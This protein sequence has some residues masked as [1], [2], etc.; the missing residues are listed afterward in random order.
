MR[1]PQQTTLGIIGAGQLG[2]MLA[3][4]GIP[5]GVK[6]VFLAS[7]NN[8]PA[9]ELGQV[10][11]PLEPGALESFL[12]AADMITYESENTDSQLIRQIQQT[13][14][15]YPGEAALYT[16]Q[17][18]FREK[19]CF[20][21]LGIPTADFALV[22]SIHSLQEAVTKIGLPAI[23]KT[24]TEGYDGKGQF[25]IENPEQINQAWL[26]IG[27]REAILEAKINFKRELS[28]VAVRSSKGELAYYP[29]VENHHRQGILRTTYAPAPNLDHSLT[30]MADAY[31]QKLLQ[32]L[33]YVG[34]M[35]LEL[36]EDEQGQL[37]ANEMAPRVHNS[38]HWSQEGAFTCQFENHVRALLGLPLGDCTLRTPYAAMVNLIG[39]T[40][41]INQAWSI[42]GAKVHLYHKTPRP[43][44][45]LGHINLIGEDFAQLKAQ[46]S[47]LE[48]NTE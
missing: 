34:V 14:P 15:V 7:G 38:G 32:S 16:A 45:K 8:L 30:Q 18:R 22:D 11:D 24:T 19:T 39:N 37:L 36:F 5:L 31:M 47:Q 12:Q 40:H 42:E 46:V 10:F 43:G 2:Q 33:D 4:A 1:D 48:N 13:H 29:L 21:Q 20:R 35:A 9:S 3:L 25:V 41:P 17:H 26:A 27:Q 6:F 23:L 28:L 44:R